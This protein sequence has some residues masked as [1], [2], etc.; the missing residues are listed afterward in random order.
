VADGTL[1]TWIETH[2]GLVGKA[3]K[4]LFRT[5]RAL[6]L[7]PKQQGIIRERMERPENRSDGVVSV[8]RFAA[9]ELNV[10]GNTLRTWL[11]ANS[12]LVGELKTHLFHAKHGVGLTPAQQ[13]IVLLHQDEIGR[14]R[15]RKL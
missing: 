6:G 10:D 12:D 4:Y 2:S 15:R 3:E 5:Y 8:R 1:R 11:K 9:A 14:K 13:R 7:T